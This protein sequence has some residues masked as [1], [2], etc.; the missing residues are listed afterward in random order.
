[1]KMHIDTVRCTGQGVCEAIRPD[2]FRVGDD[3]VAHL[4]TEQFTGADRRDLEDAVYQCP[5]QA[6][7]LE[8]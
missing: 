5:E 8:G 2:I 6:L 4:L 1:M 7:A 3:G